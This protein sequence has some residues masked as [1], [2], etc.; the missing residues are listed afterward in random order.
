MFVYTERVALAW[1]PC[2][3]QQWCTSHDVPLAKDCEGNVLVGC[4]GHAAIDSHCIYTSG[5]S[6]NT[7]DQRICSGKW[8]HQQDAAGD[9][10]SQDNRNEHGALW[11]MTGDCETV[12]DTARTA[13]G[14]MGDIISRM[15][16]LARIKKVHHAGEGERS[17]VKGKRGALYTSLGISLTTL[18]DG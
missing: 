1:Q 3:Q 14:Q 11:Y 6:N 9:T 8:G 5:D 15:G 13:T 16:R 2:S 10:G 12:R 7:W 18:G 4:T 17:I